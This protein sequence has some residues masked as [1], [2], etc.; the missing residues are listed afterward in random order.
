M[1]VTLDFETYYDD[2]FSLTKIPTLSYVADDRFEIIM[3]GIKI[4]DQ[5]TKVYTGEALT[6][7]LTRLFGPGNRSTL[8]CQN[9]MFDGLIID[10]YYG[11]KPYRYA[12]TLGMFKG[13]ANHLPASL[14]VMCEA[15]F[16]NDPSIRKTKEL[17]DFKGFRTDDFNEGQWALFETYCKNDVDITYACY[18]AMLEYFPEAELDIID[19][20]LKMWCQ[21]TFMLDGERVQNHLTNLTDQQDKLLAEVKSEFKLSKTTLSSSPQFAAWLESRGIAPPTK[22]NP[23]GKEI[24]AFAK[25]DLGF[26]DL[27]FKYP[28]LAKVWEARVSVKS[29]TEATRAQRLL[30]NANNDEGQLRVP[31]K[32]YG[33]ATGRYSGSEKINLQNLKRGSELRLSLVAKPGQ[34]VYVAD[35]AQIEAR[36]NAWLSG[37]SD[38]IADFA[39]NEDIYSKFASM[40]YGRPV[41]RKAKAI[42]SEGKEYNPDYLEGFVGKI[43][44]LGLGYGMGA[45]KFQLTLKKGAMGGPPVHFTDAEA[46]G[47]VDL[48]R[49]RNSMIAANWK[50]A[51]HLL[52]QMLDPECDVMWGPIRVLHKRMLLPNGMFINYP[53]LTAHEDHDDRVTFEY[54]NGK[55]M[56]NIYSGKVVENACQALARIVVMEQLLQACKEMPE[57]RLALQV[58]DEGV[59]T[60]PEDNP[61]PRMDRII[62]IMSTA[63]AWAEGLPLS[64]EGGFA[65]NYSK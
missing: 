55:F 4:D 42:D 33:A 27:Q 59:F 21:P 58:H 8:L 40:I 62:E 57:L 48:Y 22:T 43:A 45:P 49:A 3:C 14:Q 11:L 23:K 65:V 41:N 17:A 37:Q 29:T 24:Y 35:S 34:L 18:M 7:E 32:Y 52:H 9:T 60:G 38:L 47:I 39:N 51:Q 50:R 63:P 46:K 54:W 2:K 56:T 20:T 12:D 19:I 36:I 10:Y 31:L 44:I 61:Q 64:A 28:E 6:E 1:L 15:L 30:T 25:D 53:H 5:P 26:T 16:P 13:V